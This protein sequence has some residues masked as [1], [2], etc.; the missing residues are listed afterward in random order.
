MGIEIFKAIHIIGFVAWFSGLFYLGRLFVYH[1]E[2]NDKHEPDQSILKAQFELMQ[3]RVYKI[4]C[5][6][7]MMITWTAGLIMLY[8]YG[9]EWI[10][11]NTWIHVKLILVIVLTIYHLYGKSYIKKQARGKGNMNSLQL[12]LFN[13]I[14]TLLLFAIVIFAVFKLLA[15]AMI[16]LTAT[17][18]FGVILYVFT[19]WYKRRRESKN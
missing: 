4:I 13:E 14:P 10:K 17:L 6:P 8:L 7:A 3:Q 19:K 16:V 9:V 1:R 2:A 18:V 12:R 15:D 11:V 5:N